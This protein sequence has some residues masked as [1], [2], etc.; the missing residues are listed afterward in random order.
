MINTPRLDAAAFAAL[1]L[2]ALAACSAPP[3]A[4]VATA[5]V[6][7]PHGRAFTLNTPVH[8]IEAD[9]QGKA[10]LDRDLPGL[11]ASRDLM[12]VDDM[13]LTQIAS[14]SGGQLTQAKLA[15]LQA[16]LAQISATRKIQP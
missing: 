1:G 10:V 2:A 8:I 5:P 9:A 13:S 3:P 7:P 16:D 4:V 12:M 11:M 14:V 15:M 6:P